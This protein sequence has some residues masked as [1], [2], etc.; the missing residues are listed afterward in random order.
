MLKRLQ[1]FAAMH[2]LGQFTVADL[3]HSANVHSSSAYTVIARV[4]DG[5]LS[6]ESLKSGQRGG[7]SVL[8]K[9]TEEG[10]SGIFEEIG[11]ASE[12]TR[13][14]PPT[15]IAEAPLGLRSALETLGELA[16]TEDPEISESLRL[17]AVRDLN[18]AQKE[19]AGEAYAGNKDAILKQVDQALSKLAALAPAR[20]KLA[21]S[22][23]QEQ[24][25][26][27]RGSL[28]M[29]ARSL[30]DL[31]AASI[32]P[33]RAEPPSRIP[34]LA[35]A[36]RTGLHIII[37]QLGSDR[38]SEELALVAKYALHGALL[39]ARHQVHGLDVKVHQLRV[40]ELRTL[41]AEARGIGS[42]HSNS[43]FVL[44]VNSNSGEM[45]TRDALAHIDLTGLG[46]NCAVLDRGFSE[47]VGEFIR[48]KRCSYQPEATD[49]MQLEWVAETVSDYSGMGS[50]RVSAPNLNRQIDDGIGQHRSDH[51]MSG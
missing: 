47:T 11:R 50:N 8:Y 43:K 7:Q 46:V 18:W 13:L 41:I 51:V 27:A 21:V 9:L 10:A 30:I 49:P 23:E 14:A 35:A 3:A 42:I 26:K 48:S 19:L 36:M 40:T 17:D 6:R 25:A 32:S 20:S 37:G 1:I 22:T 44:V 45:G 2:R 16:Q 4:K 15:N 24:S 5:W 39:Q 38:G 29:M 34:Q 33:T 12:A 28:S 31:M